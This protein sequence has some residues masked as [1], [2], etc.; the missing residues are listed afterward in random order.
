MWVMARGR[1]LQ[2]LW[3]TLLALAV[4]TAVCA[5]PAFAQD[6]LESQGLKFRLI[7]GGFIC[8]GHRSVSRG[9]MPTRPRPIGSG[10]TLSISAVTETTNAQY[11][12]F[13]RPRAISRPLLG[14]QEPQRPQPAVVG[15]SW[16]DA[17][18]FCRWLTQVTLSPTNCPPRPSGEAAARGGLTGQPYPW[19][20][21]APD[22]AASIAPTCATT[23]P[24]GWLSLFGAGGLLS[25]PMTTASTTWRQCLGMCLDQY[26][27]AASGPF[28][29]GLN[30][31]A[32]RRLWFSQAR[33]LRVA[34]PIRPCR[35]MPTATSASGWCVSRPEKSCLVLRLRIILRAQHSV[36]LR[37]NQK[38]GCLME[39]SRPRLFF[40]RRGRLLSM[41]HF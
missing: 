40:C 2:T 26:V 1:I 11:A 19:G 24:P 5:L 20:A 34:A 23:G 37:H 3:I 31:P 14:G 38:A 32:E 39:D 17:A 10:W 25:R 22:E 6:V 28:K 15:V 8:W 7:P 30:A 13:S 9:A 36:P 21:E 27:P 33:D 12:R 4:G 35:N 29:P 16:E 41:V 18:A